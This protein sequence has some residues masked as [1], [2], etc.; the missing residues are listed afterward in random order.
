MG[1]TLL[2]ALFGLSPGTDIVAH[3]F[4]FVSGFLLGGVW[5]MTPAKWQ[6]SNVNVAAGMLLGFWIFVT[7]GLAFGI[8]P[9]FAH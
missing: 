8:I 7:G 2:F 9:P 4:G 1:G 3:L 6:N 5:L